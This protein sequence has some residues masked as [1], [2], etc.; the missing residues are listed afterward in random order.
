MAAMDFHLNKR[1]KVYPSSLY[2]FRNF[3]K[4]EISF[5]LM[6]LYYNIQKRGLHLCIMG[7]GG[8]EV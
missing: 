3:P 8:K 4:K 2:G 6:G 1:F 5:V 7:L